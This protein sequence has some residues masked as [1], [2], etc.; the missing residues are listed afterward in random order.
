MQI[1]RLEGLSNLFRAAVI[2]VALLILSTIFF[3]PTDDVSALSGITISTIT[4]Y[5][6]LDS[7][8][9][10]DSG[11]D[12]MYQQIQVTNSSGSTLTD[13]T[14][15]HSGFTQPDLTGFTGTF[16]LDSGESTTR[17]IPT[18]AN[19]ATA[20]VYYFV[21]YPCYSGSNPP[22]KS[23]TYTITVSQDGNP[24]DVTSGSLSLT[25]RSEIS[26]NAGG[27]LVSQQI[28]N[29]AV[30]GQIIPLTVQYKFGNIGSGA[31]LGIQPAGNATH[32][33]GCYRLV[34]TDITGVSG[35]TGLTT[36]DDD[37]LYKTGVSSG[38]GTNTIDV[39]YY[40]KAVCVGGAGTTTTPY[41]DM[42]SGTQQKY[43]GNFEPALTCTGSKAPS[44]CEQKFPA[45]TNPFTI[46]KTASPTSLPSGGTVTYTIIVQNTSA[47]DARL[48][49]ITDVL[50]AISGN[51]V[52]F[53]A[54]TVNSDI[55][56]ANSAS[57]PSAGDDGTINFI[58]KPT[59]SCVGGTCDGTY[60][61]AGGSSLKLEYTATVPN[62]VGKY[63]NT[64]T[65]Y[66]E[67]ISIGSDT[68]EVTVG[69]APTVAKSFSPA[70]ISAGG[71]STLTITLNNSN[72]SAL[73]ID[74]LADAYPAGVVN[75]ST[76]NGTT[77]CSGGSVTAVAGAGSVNIS[78]GTIPASGSCT[79]TVTVTS[80]TGG[81]H[82]N[83]IAVG[84][85]TTTQ[86]LSNSNSTS[87]TL[88]VI[89]PPTVTK[90][91]SSDVIAEGGTS[92]LTITVTNPN[93]SGIS[94]VAFTDTYPSGVVNAATPSASTTCTGGSASA[95]GGGNTVSLSNGAI[96]ASSS[97]TV[98]VTVT[99]ASDGSYNNSIPIGDVSSSV[100][101]NTVAASD[102]LTV[103]DPPSISKS[104]GTDP[105]A[106][107]GTSTLTFTI[108][109]PNSGNSL[110]GVAFTD[111]LPS[112][113]KVAGTPDA[114]ATDCGS[115]TWSPSADDT[116]L[117]FSGGT[118][119]ASGTCTV[120]VDV[121]ATS[122]GAKV[123]TSGNVSST[124]GGTGN[125][126]SDTLNVYTA[127]TLTKAFGATTI[128]K[129][130]NTTLTLTL[131]NPSGNPGALTTVKVDDTFP[132]GMTLQN[133]TFNFT[134]GAC[135]T[136]TKTDD[137]ASAAGDGAV[138]FS[139]ASIASGSSCQVVMN[140]T[141][142]TAGAVTNTTGTPTATGPVSLTG[143]TA[144][145]NLTVLDPPSI[146]KAFSP[147]PIAVNGTSTLTF[148]ITNPNSGDSLTGV[149]FTDNL[150]SG[151]KVA[152]TPDVQNTC[153]GTVTATAGSTSISLGGGSIS[154]GSNC[155][156]EVDV[157]ATSA[158]AKANTS[159][160]V[161]STNGGTG[162]TASDTLT[163]N[164]TAD[165]SGNVSADTDNDG[166]GDTNL[167]NI[168][169]KL[170]LDADG[171][172]V[173]DTPG[174]PTATTTTNASGNY[175]FSGVSLNKYIVV[176]TDGAAYPDDVS[177]S[178]GNANGTDY[179]TIKVD[180]S[181]GSDSTGN[182]FVDEKQITISG[183]VTAD[184]DN[185][186]TGDTNLNNITV[187]LYLDADGN[188]MADTPGTPTAT[189]TTN[190]SGVYSFT[191]VTAGKYIVVETDGTSYPDDVSDSDGNANGTDYDTIKVDVSGGSDSTGNNFVDEKQITISGNV[192]A[193]TDNDDTGDTNL[194][195]I[196]VTL[197]ADANDDGVA[198]GAAV[199]TTTTDASG[200]YSFTDVTAGKY[201]VVETDGATYPDDVS[202]KDGTAGGT[203]LDTIKVDVSGGS[204]STGNDFVDEKQITI[205]GTVYDD[206]N[207]DGNFDAG[208]NGIPSVAVYLDSNKNGVK[209]AGEPEDTTNA[210]GYYE[211]PDST[212]GTYDIREINPASYASTGDTEGSNDD[213]ISITLSAGSD[214]TGNDFFDAQPADIRG[215]VYEDSNG[216]G[217]YDAGETGI[218]GVNVYLDLND[219]GVKDAGEP[220]DTTDANGDYEFVD[221]NPGTY[222]IRETNPAGYTSTGDTNGANDDKIS[223]TLTSGTD[224]D[225]NDF[226][227]IQPSDIRGTVYED[228]NG[229]GNFDVGEDGLSGVNVYLDLNDNGV[230]DTGEPEGTTD[231][232]GDYEF[233][234]LNPGTYVIRETNPANYVST[235]D[236]E[237]GNDDK[238]SVTLTSGVDSQDND[239]FDDPDPSVIRGSV[240]DDTN[241]D[242]D[243]DAGE[244]GI[245]GVTV[246][247]DLNN[248]GVSDAGEPEDVT[249]A[250]G[251]YEF[252]SLDPRDY[253]IREVNKSGYT[254]TG[255]TEGANDD[256]INVAVSAGETEANHDFFD[257]VP[258][259][260]RGTVYD[261]A[262]GDGDFDAGETGISGVTAYLD[263]N[264]NGV[265]DAGEPE[266][267]T[268]ASGDY[269]FADKNPGTYVI[270][271]INPAGH[272]SSGDIDGA[273]DDKISVTL[274]SGTD[275][276]D[277]DFFDIKQAAIRGTVYEDT[278]GDGDYDAGEPGATG[279]TVYLDLNDNG[280]KD[281]GEPE[282]TTDAN[283][284]YE[285][286]NLDPGTYVV[287][288][289]NPTNYTST[290]DTGGANDDKIT[291]TLTSGTDS[292]D[293]DF[294]DE[295]DPGTIQGTVYD[296]TNVNGSFDS[297]EP[298]LSGVIVYLDLNDDGVKDAGEPE[299]TTDA[300]GDYQFTNLSPG[301]YV[302]REVNKTN[303]AS[304]G[305]TN[306]ANDD[307]ISVTLTAGSTSVDNDF[308]DVLVADLSLV[309]GASTSTP[310]A[311]TTITFTITVTN[312]GPNS[313]TNITV[314]DMVPNGY[315][316]T[317]GAGNI[318]SDSGTTGATITSDESSAPTLSWDID[319]LD[320]GESVSLTVK[321]LVNATGDY[322]NLAQITA[323]DQPDP[324]SDPSSDE[325]TDDKGDG[326]DDDDESSTSAS[327]GAADLSISKKVDNISAGP[328]DYVVF[329]LTLKNDGPANASGLKVGDK[330][331]DGYAYVTDNP[332]QGTYDD[333]SGEWDVGAIANGST[334]TL[335]I[336]AKVKV[337]GDYKNVA[338]VTASNQND[339]DSTPNNDDGDQSEDD[340]AASKVGYSHVF[341]PPSGWKF[342]DATGWPTA[343]WRQVWIN[344]GN[345]DANPVR[346]VD[347]MPNGTSYVAGSLVCEAR[348]S[349]TTTTCTYD[350]AADQIVWEGTIAAD[351][352]ALT[353]AD[354]SNEVVLTFS[355]TIPAGMDQTQNQGKAYWDQ[356]GDGD[357]DNDDANVAN[358]TP[359]LTD[360]SSTTAPKDPT[361]A[362]N[363][364]K[365][366]DMDLEVIISDPTARLGDVVTF[367]V[368]VPNR[369]TH[370]ATGISVS[371]ILPAGYT[372]QAGTIGGNAGATGA[373]IVSDDSNDPVLKWDVDQLDAS[374][375]VTLTFQARING[376]FGLTNT[377]QVTAQD[378]PDVDSAPNNDDGDQ[379]EDDED[380]AGITTAQLGNFAWIDNNPKNGL[381]DP[382]EP[383]VAN[384]KVNL[385][386]DLDG[387]GQ[388][389]PF[390][391]D[392]DV[393]QTQI[394]GTDGSYLFT[395]APG[396]YMIEFVLPNGYVLTIENAGDDALDNDAGQLQPSQL[397]DKVWLDGNKDGIQDGDEIGYANV[398]LN[399]FTD[400]DGDGIVE[401]YT[402]DGDPIDTIITDD[403][404]AF[405]FVVNPGIY[406]IEALRPAGWA[407]TE[408]DAGPDDVDNDFTDSNT[409]DTGGFVFEGDTNGEILDTLN[410]SSGGFSPQITIDADTTISHID[411]GL[412]WL[413]A[414][415]PGMDVYAAYEALQESL[416]KT[417][418]ENSEF[419]LSIGKQTAPIDTARL[420]QAT[421]NLQAAGR[422]TLVTLNPGSINLDTDVGVFV[423]SNPLAQ[424]NDDA[425]SA[426]NAVLE[427]ALE[428]PSTG[429]TPGRQTNVDPL[430]EII[431]E[432]LETNV[433][434]MLE[435]PSLGVE[436]PIIGI[437]LYNDVWQTTWLW[438]EIGY[439]E[440]TAFPTSMGNTALSAH[441]YLPTGE[442][443]PFVDLDQLS[444]G[445]LVIIDSGD[446]LYM[447]EVRQRNFVAPDDLSVMRRESE[448]WITLITCYQYDEESG[449]YLWRTVV[450][451][452]LI[453]IIAK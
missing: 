386:G 30:L 183:T 266:D 34:S 119:A 408:L 398:T 7:N 319:Q 452:V 180:V 369:G 258:A 78:G 105:I 395:V 154:G 332:S 128:A 410:L 93:S 392:S 285:F 306:G 265:K 413:V 47:Y 133:T 102:T 316:Y 268:D 297:G 184:T 195:N 238:I 67:G 233:A 161:S 142:S 294:F 336:S 257:A 158:G 143:S 264:D 287:R 311:G 439:L 150:P 224:S 341:D 182:N 225:D 138:R 409:I 100:G 91:F 397:G 223:V 443:G 113:V 357:I 282:D 167:N 312:S 200:V 344:N 135:G 181:G 186:G 95:T 40:L 35:V 179:D 54:F 261:D 423:S 44:P 173:A 114:S 49:K 121:T 85:L 77:T 365:S 366:V 310:V 300:N 342:V 335:E 241:G 428:L 234:D 188:G 187:K 126:A 136:V 94:S 17:T 169:V 129:G 298:G 38:G 57:V 421:N 450:R 65:G 23:A 36:S 120:E 104:F 32:N 230:K 11:P 89:A 198:D 367:T 62:Y 37:V 56:A 156:V 51:K 15:T 160:N 192:K 301:T 211:F 360:D 442:P 321:A 283:G 83:T 14:V 87:A 229:D 215:T 384:V 380:S 29:G 122:A 46:S 106:V 246:Y 352:G 251:A 210:S 55:T 21:N 90:E 207:G 387:D 307:K 414:E 333:S 272:N 131:S 379:S 347:S 149:A 50:P 302:V 60:W 76:P 70:S 203:D 63:T 279:V 331:P 434:M 270:R 356:D 115:P 445:N 290:G 396:T 435:I 247:L 404:G 43:T 275:S 292:A 64:A 208:E 277:N 82:E 235:G 185:N 6:T 346:I 399:L 12:A 451:A 205:S 239:F 209:D 116:S 28:G 99:A 446:L 172:G 163:V 9:S 164:A 130:G 385:Y 338:Q 243:F 382:G 3:H 327:P 123:N 189:K 217:D 178:D 148:T 394:T 216:D 140:V 253:I 110:T 254:S 59:T 199:A 314:T 303:Y 289:I 432:Q 348:G 354:A 389:E 263:L 228:L 441:A 329:T 362:R 249:D 364:N 92:T 323:A 453:D 255:D 412:M 284:D 315:T 151:V 72:G 236:T 10:C 2:F 141:S 259:D 213:K 101:S 48:E 374:E 358:N 267:T 403:S 371:D 153:N 222:V 66:S 295:P 407:C 45:P 226:F 5:V 13:L 273:N 244:P 405:E 330:L 201:I 166:T 190:A 20:N 75:A 305:D 98:T 80:S 214:S 137:T 107:N 68:S 171:N 252:L 276:D 39:V 146:S 425:D 132:A 418:S 204:D 436:S 361:A 296:D 152:G 165:I 18:L 245:A 350:A 170:Y 191:D 97:C 299:A 422:A 343:I 22:A 402:D 308:F 274:T 363:P 109:N 111:N 355:T 196:T 125:T 325:N 262:N 376:E 318:D 391:D 69:T 337:S 415:E 334:A 431:K 231:A 447:Y 232:N 25:T 112:G 81:S 340:E 449:K 313:A 127:P 388:V 317:S 281:A 400:V 424:L 345:A 84:D 373:T 31:D 162:N 286:T 390:G 271:E 248:N 401:P 377:T 378:Q 444:W 220:E 86:E 370:S 291:V 202:D 383:G 61:I 440:G 293:N 155:T 417:Y 71:T 124:N 351:Q 53:S 320:V 19:G 117:S 139:A 108:T 433:D 73:T 145:D 368:T 176:E 147:D 79:I 219:N 168:T 26:A 41:A 88:T 304:T 411:M 1:I 33:S 197:Y 438:N 144:S 212:P 324:D 193:D 393:M 427:D 353:E 177:D 221:R 372:Y 322:T 309:K 206:T 328:G 24:P 194:N 237:G 218:S 416:P 157:T 430:P 227:D 74:S 240:Y 288:E 349:S 16:T 96:A 326:L 103:L 420:L 4:P 118:I 448:D 429:F 280:V 256:T 242:G 375:S 269:E 42:V 159:G 250:L 278:N 134:P 260:I 8:D 406:M 419:G 175:T 359:V 426:S 27:E 437:P 381:Q 58:G 339:P 52:T 174:T